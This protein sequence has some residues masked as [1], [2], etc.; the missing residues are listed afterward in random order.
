MTKRIPKLAAA[1]ALL[2]AACS[3]AQTKSD[4]TA[5]EVP[6]AQSTQLAQAQPTPA[7]QYQA[8][9][10]SELDKALADLRGVQ[11]FFQF[12]AAT[13]TPEAEQKLG[14]VAEILGRH[15]ELRVSIAGNCDERGS[16]QYNL[17]LG[18][19]RADSARKYLTDLG[20]TRGQITAI[21]FG[22][23]KPVATGHDEQ[24]W[25]QNRRDDLTAQK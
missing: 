9:G 2:L 11:V 8:Q 20:V 21:S 5:V 18:Q 24:A 15:P 1:A 16:E 25:K 23:E 3:H 12:D 6:V 13:L 14:A 4:T 22:A 7:Q 10:Q 19:G 17:A